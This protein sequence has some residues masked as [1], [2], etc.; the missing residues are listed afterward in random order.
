[1][2][3]TSSRRRP[4]AVPDASTA[5][6]DTSPWVRVA[7]I[8]RPHGVHGELRVWPDNPASTLLFEDIP[9]RLHHEGKPP[10][11]I[12]I[13]AIRDT[14][15][16][17]LVM[18]AGVADREG[19]ATLTHGAL[20]V[21]RDVL[22]QLEDGEFYHIDVIGAAVLDADTGAHLGTVKAF[23]ETSVDVLVVATERGEVLVPILADIV[24]SIGEEPGIVRVRNLDDWR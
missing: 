16:A 6:D 4:P 10:R 17:L 21:P 18:F 5:G 15:D 8:G 2:S 23:T 22:P 20:E 1:M 14:G 3:A 11:P 13:D 12:T 9:L 7:V 24:P 19:A